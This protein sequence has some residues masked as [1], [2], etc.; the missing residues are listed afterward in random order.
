MTD[1]GYIIT[2]HSLGCVS[3][4]CKHD[5]GSGS[6]SVAD[7]LKTPEEN[8]VGQIKN[9]WYGLQIFLSSLKASFSYPHQSQRQNLTSLLIQSTSLKMTHAYTPDLGR[10]L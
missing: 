7:V 1:E 2:A 8:H 9:S 5:H 10:I 6:R 4:I 3:K